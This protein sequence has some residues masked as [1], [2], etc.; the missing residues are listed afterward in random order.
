MAS[1]VNGVARL[2][3]EGDGVRQPKPQ[4]VEGFE[5][6]ADGRG[7]KSKRAASPALTLNLLTRTM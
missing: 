1:G 3:T 7:I 4:P 6:T 5:H 2:L